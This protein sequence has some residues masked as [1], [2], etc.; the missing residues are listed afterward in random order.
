MQLYIKNILKRLF[1]VFLHFINIPWMALSGWYC[2]T[3]PQSQKIW[4]CNAH[5]NPHY[6]NFYPPSMVEVRKELESI[7]DSSSG[8]VSVFSSV[9]GAAHSLLGTL[10]E[11]LVEKRKR[12]VW[13]GFEF[14]GYVH[15]K[16]PLFVINISLI[17]SLLPNH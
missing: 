17:Q 9:P 7:M 8:Y 3:R 16:V 5:P 15:F 6:D 10:E 4:L 13:P 1:V 14:T 11:S 2:W 12:S